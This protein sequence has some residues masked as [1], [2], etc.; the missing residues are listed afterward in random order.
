MMSITIR[1][2]TQI[3]MESILRVKTTAV[4]AGGVRGSSDFVADIA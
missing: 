1:N 3:A 4:D 2:H